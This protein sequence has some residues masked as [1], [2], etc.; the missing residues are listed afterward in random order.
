MK[1]VT[2]LLSQFQPVHYVLNIVPNREAK[3]F[4]GSVVVSGKKTGRPS[5]RLTFHAKDLKIT[6]CHLVHH[7]KSGDIEMTIDRVNIHKAYDEVRLHTKEQLYPGNYTVTLEF[8]GSI[9]T[10]MDGM[11]PCDFNHDGKEK[12]LIATQFESHHAREVFPCIDEPE[13][14]ATFELS[15]TTPANEAVLSNTPIRAQEP[16]DGS[17]ELVRTTFE[18]T[19]HMSTYLLAFVYGELGY[20]EAKTKRGV[21]VRTHATPDNVE[22]TQ[23]ALDVAVKCLDYYSEYFGI[24]YPLEKCDMIALPDFASGAMENWGCITYR[25]QTLLVDPEHTSIGMK[26]YVAMVVAHELTHQWFGN[27]VT[28]SWWTD[29]WLNEGF[30][31]WF[32]YLALDHLFPEWNMWTQF[33]VDDQQMA[34]RSDALEH[35]HP[36]EVEVKHPDEIRTIFDNISY[37]KGASVIHMLYS[38]LGAKDFQTGLQYYLKKFS[39]KNTVTND[40]WQSLEEASGK[41]VADFMHR[42]T[43]QS[44]FPIVHATVDDRG[45]SLRQER[46]VLNPSFKKGHETW[47]I[48]LL[49]HQAAVPD[50]MK[51]TELHVP[52]KNADGLLLNKGCNGFYRTVYNATHLQTIMKRIKTGHL[53]NL[54]RLSVLADI[55]E[56]AKAGEADTVEV[57]NLLYAYANED[58]SAVWDVIAGTLG[59]V[60]AVMNDDQ[61][62]EDMKP[63]VRQLVARQVKRLGWEVS[64][65]DSHFDRL[66]RP[67]VLS[68]A[69]GAEESEIVIEAH[70]R[71][72]DLVKASKTTTKGTL[73]DPDLRSVVYSTVA[74]HGGAKEFEQ[75][76]AMHNASTN[77]EER[78]NLTAAI[79][80]FENRDMIK[81]A[82]AMIKTKEVRIQDVSYWIAYCFSNRFARELSWQWLQKNWQWLVKNMGTD[83][84]FFR[85]PVYVARNYSDKA[86]IIEYKA[87]FGAVLTPAF[88]R[89]YDQG[90]EMIQWQS[91]WRE[92]DLHEVQTFFATQKLQ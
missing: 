38:Y 37:H 66:L 28:M 47:P 53:T 33:I 17:S 50:I 30:A 69:A 85:M 72:A 41:P 58:D 68:M 60:R 54:E 20:L 45:L 40:L 65:T 91:A 34:F 75:M 57:L 83:L 32:E 86:F 78:L 71:F 43:S 88:K 11:Y 39:Y 55:S 8:S 23:F 21:T 92:R 27:L 81:K 12:Q 77:N 9:T 73:T 64:D 80:G 79:C 90:L 46:F 6:K 15:L 18:Q 42:W 4:H 89:P 48:P 2:R 61:V 29:L 5:H 25:E 84:S 35:T 16:V 62:R 82:L 22:H 24:D 7:A 14:K 36:I 70:K 74:R 26:Q 63:F 44:G 13:A 3:K 49:S 10:N 76:V 59:S 19:P 87:F 1:K 56:A 52:L 31:S 67:T 51:H